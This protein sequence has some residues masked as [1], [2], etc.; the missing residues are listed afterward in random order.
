M[1]KMLQVAVSFLLLAIGSLQTITAHAQGTAFTYQGRLNTGGSPANGSYDLAFTLYTTNV[2]GSLFAGP[3]TNS[4]VGVTNGLFTTL[5]DFGNVFYGTSNWLQI[6]VSTIAANN[7][8]TLSPRQQLTPLP[9]AV[10]AANVSGPISSASISGTIPLAQLPPAVVT[11][12]AGGLN[13]SGNFSGNG[14]GLAGVD[15]R[16]VNSLG[17][18][19]FTT[20]SPGTFTLASSPSVGNG[21]RSVVTAD[22][23]GDGKVDL[24]SAN[25]N[26]ASLTVLTNNGS[27]GFG[28]ASTLAVG[29][30]PF[31]VAAAD[32][33]GDGKVDLISAN[34]AANTLTVLTNNGSGGFGLAATLG[35]GSTPESVAAAD[36]NG[37][38]KVDLISANAN[39][40]SLT[41]LTNNGSGGFG[42]ASTLGVGGGPVSVAAADVNGDGNVDLIIANFNASSLTVLTNNGSGGFVVAS[43][44][45]VGNSP[46][47]VLAAD[48]NGDG[49]PDLISANYGANTLTVLTNNGSG[50]FVVASSP[51]V[52]SPQISVA[53]AD[54]NGDGK[55]DLIS[56][57]A[58]FASLT[59]LT[60]NGSGGFAPAS[61][62][63]LG[64]GPAWVAA[65]D[66]N[67]DGKVDLISANYGANTLTVL[68]NT[69][70]YIGNFTGNGSGLTSLNAA[71]LT[72]GTV[73]D[74][75]LSANVA[76]REGG[77]TFDGDQTVFFG[78]ENVLLG[79]IGIGT[80][81][82]HFPLSFA[83]AAGEKISLYGQ[84]GTAIHGI[85]IGAARMEFYVPS[86]NHSFVFGVGN[87]SNF[88]EKV[89]IAG[90]GTVSAA[91]LRSPGAGQNTGT[92]A[93]KQVVNSTNIYNYVYTIID[94]P[95]C[96]GDPNAILV[97]T[98]DASPLG[99]FKNIPRS[100]IYQYGYWMIFNED[101]S[102]MQIGDTF[103]VLIIK[104]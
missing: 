89:R 59:I 67:G 8:S 57:N 65:A 92:F 83:D 90:D 14:A 24:I 9:Y 46:L 1:K 104:N 4:A 75:R 47:E 31:V 51:D 53:A 33:N 21:P 22:V 99:T 18:I 56:A 29:S 76:L 58:N 43:S 98:R 61:S 54:V 81:A 26:D 97:I 72:S 32:V 88:A 102:A 103:N 5:V 40:N 101:T 30:R 84:N 96:N 12:G 15:L 68:F 6:A 41:I 28:L 19:T 17:A 7:F 3:V 27:G 38:G 82:P 94:N 64:S 86:T 95:L 80:T 11:N 66:V 79:N 35:V 91:A 36:V 25:Y 100:V 85:G 71:N 70:P 77:N 48:V 62:P 42:L 93:F 45:A 10:T 2:T 13:L 37:D 63:G 50:G 23:N 87:N 49:K 69:A 73:A 34:Y 74:A 44:P 52:G 16:T 55:V 78:N 39:G 60:N 20:N